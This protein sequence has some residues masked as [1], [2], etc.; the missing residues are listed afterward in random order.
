MTNRD[1]TAL[2]DGLLPAEPT[3]GDSSSNE[4]KGHVQ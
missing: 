1:T 3:A 2:N 4:E